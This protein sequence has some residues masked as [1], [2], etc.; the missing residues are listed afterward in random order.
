MKSHSRIR[1]GGRCLGRLLDRRQFQQEKVP[2]QP[3]PLGNL[4]LPLVVV[5]AVLMLLLVMWIAKKRPWKR[6]AGLCIPLIPAIIGCGIAYERTGSA[7]S[8]GS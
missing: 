6:P 7:K 3:Y 2:L 5:V 4:L 8:M 1:Y